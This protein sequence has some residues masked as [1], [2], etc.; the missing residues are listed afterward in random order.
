[1][2]L[3]VAPD[4]ASNVHRRLW[5][6]INQR[7]SIPLP[8]FTCLAPF[9]W[10]F[11]K[12]IFALTEK[13][14][15]VLVFGFICPFDTLGFASLQHVFLHLLKRPLNWAR[16]QQNLKKHLSPD[17][18][19]TTGN[20]GIAMV[21]KV[22]DRHWPQIFAQDGAILAQALTLPRERKLLQLVEQP[23]ESLKVFCRW[24]ENWIQ[25]WPEILKN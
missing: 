18:E 13:R 1:M 17:Q 21:N 15:Q 19:V 24:P 3:D 23:G 16:Q 4:L 5:M 2:S 11:L 14:A 9:M 25:D 22:G 20:T 8:L 10:F 6:A 7:L 12:P